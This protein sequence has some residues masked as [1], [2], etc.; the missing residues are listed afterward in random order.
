MFRRVFCG[1]DFWRLE[2]N[3]LSTLVNTFSTE[4]VLTS[5]D[6][7]GHRT[8]SPMQCSEILDC[9]V[10]KSS[11][12][13]SKKV[14]RHRKRSYSQGERSKTVRS[15]GFW[16]KSTPAPPNIIKYDLFQWSL[17]L[18]LFSLIFLYRNVFFAWDWNQGY[19]SVGRQALWGLLMG[20]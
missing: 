1:F 20:L 12:S 15:S 11:I 18:S 2:I 16:S 3:I 10:L 8:T 9:T 19:L 5:V 14:L 17:V 13:A 7:F 6:T 4:K